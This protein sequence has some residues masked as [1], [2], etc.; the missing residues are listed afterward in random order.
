MIRWQNSDRPGWSVISSCKYLQNEYS[1]PL[2]C[3]SHPPF[4]WYVN[5]MQGV[6]HLF[7]SIEVYFKEAH[8]SSDQYDAANN[9]SESLTQYDQMDMENYVMHKANEEIELQKNASG[10]VPFHLHTPDAL[11]KVTEGI[12]YGIHTFSAQRK[13]RVSQNFRC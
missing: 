10:S 2:D 12:P 4:H 11:F 3:S 1:E 8:S 13:L 6:C 5:P 9:N 7:S